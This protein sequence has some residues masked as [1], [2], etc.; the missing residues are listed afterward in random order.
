[1]KTPVEKMTF[2][3]RQHKEKTVIIFCC[4]WGSI[5]IFLLLSITDVPRAVP[6]F[7][8][9]AQE[10][11]LFLFKDLYTQDAWPGVE[12]NGTAPGEFP[13]LVHYFWCGEKIFRFEDYLGLL[14]VVRVLRPQKLVFHYHA[15]PYVDED[16]YH[17]WFQELK[18]SVPNLVLRHTNLTP[19]CGSREV[20]AFGLRQLADEGGIYVGER[21]VLTHFPGEA[22]SRE[23]SYFNFRRLDLSHDVSQG[24]VFSRFGFSEASLE[25]KVNEIAASTNSCYTVE[26]YNE[27][28]RLS[29]GP[30]LKPCLVLAESVYPRDVWNGTSPFAELARWLFYGKRSRLEVQPGPEND[31][32]IPLISHMVWIGSDDAANP[33]KFQFLH[34]L[35][36]VSAL[37]VAGFR[38]VF[39]HGESEPTGRW[40]DRLQHENVTFVKIQRPETVFQQEVSGPSQESGVLRLHTLLKHGGA[41]QER[42]VI[43]VSKLPDSIRRYP[44]VACVDWARRGEWPEVFNMGVVLAKPNADWLKS[45]MKTFSFYREDKWA[46]NALMMPYKAYELH[47][48]QLYVDTH[49]QVICFKGVCHPAWRT[50]YI[51]ELDDLQPIINYDWRHARAF[52]FIVPKPPNSLASPEAIKNGIGMFSEIGRMVLEKSG[53]SDLLK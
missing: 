11:N 48:D 23:F 26:E 18:Q 38:R 34:Y 39:V 21:T 19:R 24:V 51:R 9:A 49:L 6:S 28:S 5:L 52:H 30:T 10:D 22:F 17:T 29:L 31:D 1:M 50:D 15:L 14:S 35:S 53:Q 44:A 40:W 47:P 7:F 41:Y 43:W 37:H 12:A 3:L 33:S 27:A 16:W 25:N 32:L 36:V 20:L 13:Y 46:F 45:F 2:A 42:D 4:V 8:Y